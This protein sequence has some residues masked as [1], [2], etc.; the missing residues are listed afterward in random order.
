MDVEETKTITLKKPVVLNEK[1][2]ETL[3]LREPTGDEIDQAQR[4]TAS[5]M[6]CNMELIA[7][8]SGAPVAVIKKIGVSQ[9]NEASAFLNTFMKDAPET[10]EN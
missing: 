6:A 4:I 7:R 2:Y 3:E 8:V 5:P 1:T 10:T 9:I